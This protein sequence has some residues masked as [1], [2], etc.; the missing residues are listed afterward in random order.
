MNELSISALLDRYQ[1]ARG[2]AMKLSEDQFEQLTLFFPGLLITASD[3]E[4]DEE[5]WVYIKYLAR[6][7][8]SIFSDSLSKLELQDLQDSYFKEFKY[9]LENLDTWEQ[10]FIETL[11]RHLEKNGEFKDTV[12]DALY[13]FAE[14]SDGTSEEEEQA[15]NSLTDMLNLES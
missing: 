14:A 10:E 1:Q 9:L 12:L 6:F 11:K 7:T 15:I 4:I 13:L 2:K 5:E 8:S 3:G